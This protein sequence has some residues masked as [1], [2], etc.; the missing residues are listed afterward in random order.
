MGARPRQVAVIFNPASGAATRD[1]AAGRRRAIQAA[2]AAHGVQTLWYETTRGNPGR[3]SAQLAV[4]HGV[5]VLLVSGGDGTVMACARALVGTAIPLAIIPSG[6]GNIVAAS[7]RVPT[8]VM[9]ATE[10]ALRGNRQW[11]DIGASGPDHTL[12]AASMGFGAAVMRDATP[13]LKARTGMLAYM[14]SAVRHLRDSS[15]TFR[16][17]IDDEPMIVQKSDGVLV[18]NFG[19]LMTR[20]RLPQASLDDGL[21][22]VGILR[23][24]P[25][26]DWLRQDLPAF[27][28]PRRPPLDWY[29]ARHVTVDCDRS[30]PTER[31]GDWVGS[32]SHLEVHV[33]PRSLM[34][35]VPGSGGPPPP[36]RPLL[37]WVAR[38]VRK[39]VCRRSR[40]T[41]TNLGTCTME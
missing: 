6:T 38:D 17:R 26:L 18:G 39:V 35:C 4:T 27:R 23:I 3:A 28:P 37:H 1:G 30:Q 20:P 22:E 40:Y 21:L 16:L 11:I 12:F 32:S 19:Q 5:D 24:R 8:G 33:L 9:E 13:A 14:L 25:F 2:L 34:V 31:D 7:L 10:V 15:V 29:Q 41:E 36:M